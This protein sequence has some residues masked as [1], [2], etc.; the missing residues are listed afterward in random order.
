MVNV[1]GGSDEVQSALFKLEKLAAAE[2]SADVI[3]REAT[4]IDKTVTDF[5]TEVELV[6]AEAL[7]AL[8]ISAGP[9]SLTMV[10][11]DVA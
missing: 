11:T 4:K 6:L 1:R 5:A 9:T 2:K 7:T 8:T 10:N 3:R